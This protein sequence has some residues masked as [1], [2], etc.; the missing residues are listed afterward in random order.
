M[1]GIAVPRYELAR[2]VLDEGQGTKSIV[3]QLEQPLRMAEGL[4]MPTKRHWT[5]VG[6]KHWNHY[7][8]KK[9]ALSSRTQLWELR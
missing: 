1:E 6:R 5:D 7:R 2:S 8:K 4:R 9:A 3:L